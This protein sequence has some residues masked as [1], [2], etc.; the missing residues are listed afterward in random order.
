MIIMSMIKMGTKIVNDEDDV[1]DW[2]E[3]DED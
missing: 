3:S 1:E 2:N